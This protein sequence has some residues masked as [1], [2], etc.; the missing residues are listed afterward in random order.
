VGGKKGGNP[1]VILGESNP[2]RQGGVAGSWIL[3]SNQPILTV[4]IG[5]VG[6]YAGLALS[7]TVLEPE[8]TGK[9]HR[10]Y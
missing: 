10:Y 5:G 7:G 4:A 1:S 8:I 2:R 6:L 9:N 3:H